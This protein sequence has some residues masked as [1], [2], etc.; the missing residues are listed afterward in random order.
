MAVV[1]AAC[2]A[3]PE[4]TSTTVPPPD[5]TTTTLQDRCPDT[6]CVVLHI[7]PEASWSDGTPVSAADFA[8]TL[9]LARSG[10]SPDPAYDMVTALEVGPEGEVVV[11]F[12]EVTGAFLGLFRH[13]LPAHDPVA[14]SG[15]FTFDGERLESGRSTVE[16]VAATGVRGAVTAMRAGA[17]DLAWIPDPPSWAVEELR[18]VEGVTLHAGPGPDWE[19]ITFNQANPLL[20]NDWVREAIVMAL[21]RDAMA[22]ATVRLVDPSADLAD[23]TIPGVPTPPYPFAHDPDAARALL[24]RNGC[25]SGESGALSCGGLPLSFR[26]VTTSGDPWRRMISEMAADSLRAIGVDVSVTEMVP[27]ELFAATHLFGED[28]DI[29]VFSWEAQRDPVAAADIYRCQGEGPHGFGLLNVGRH[30]G[31]DALIEEA[32]ASFDTDRRVALMTEVDR[33]F[34]GSAAIVPL[35]SRPVVAAWSTA[36][37]GV[38]TGTFAGPLDNAGE[39]TGTIRFAAPTQPDVRNLLY[40]SAFTALPGGGY[41]PDLVIDFETFGG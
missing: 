2:T 7:D 13:V 8:N 39:W 9:E 36:V 23:S 12:A 38:E 24:Q 37:T 18:A 1:L 6:F 25:V 10:E 32:M 31:D 3:A 21:D 29:A 17:A 33:E 27:A 11:A 19:M 22:D 28:W 35:F 41:F 30:C 5:P 20:A 4:A 16:M 15:E 14:T 26:W 34:V 40:R